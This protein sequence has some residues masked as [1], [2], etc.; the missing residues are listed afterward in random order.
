MSPTPLYTGFDTNLSGLCL[1]VSSLNIIML[2]SEWIGLKLSNY[3]ISKMLS[4]S[5][6]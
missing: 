6:I 4:N 2:K 1:S 3:M 5:L